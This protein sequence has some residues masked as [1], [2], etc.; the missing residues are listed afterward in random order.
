MFGLAL[1]S[2]FSYQA[3]IEELITQELRSDEEQQ[4]VLND[5]GRT[6]ASAEQAV[7]TTHSMVKGAAATYQ[8]MMDEEDS[9]GKGGT[10]SSSKGGGRR[11]VWRKWLGMKNAAKD[12]ATELEGVLDIIS[13]ERELF[14]AIRNE[15]LQDTR[16]IL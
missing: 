14:D 9:G 11:G 16:A 15:G 2:V 8:S 6:I 13:T 5:Y 7:A 3:L 10:V 1:S 12:H 4:A